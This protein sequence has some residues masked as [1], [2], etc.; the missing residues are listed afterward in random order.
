MQ[1][2]S[3]RSSVYSHFHT[4]LQGLTSIRAYGAQRVLQNEF[5]RYMVTRKNLICRAVTFVPLND[6]L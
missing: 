5:H 4:S 3:A 1:L 2:L 6:P